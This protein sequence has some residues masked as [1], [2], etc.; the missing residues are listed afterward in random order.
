MICSFI[1][2][3]DRVTFWNFFF[4]SKHLQSSSSIIL[5]LKRLKWDY[6]DLTEPVAKEIEPRLNKH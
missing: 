4:N 3:N 6:N 2:N 1:Y 5:Y